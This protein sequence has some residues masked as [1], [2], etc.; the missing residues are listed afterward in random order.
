MWIGRFLPHTQSE[1][2]VDS[3][4]VF[5]QIFYGRQQRKRRLAKTL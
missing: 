3:V 4:G 2:V 1:K 5:A